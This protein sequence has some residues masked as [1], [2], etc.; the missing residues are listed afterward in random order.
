MP[1]RRSGR[2][3]SLDLAPLFSDGDGHAYMFPRG[4]AILVRASGPGLIPSATRVAI[5]PG[6]VTSRCALS[7]GRAVGC[8]V[9]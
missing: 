3:V 2:G 6:L 5:G 4:A 1:V 7:G 8:R 9:R